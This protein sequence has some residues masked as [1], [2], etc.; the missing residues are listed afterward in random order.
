MGISRKGDYACRI[1]RAC[2]RAEGR[3]ISVAEIAEQEDIPYSFARSIQHNLVRAGFLKT[4]RGARG[5]V[6]L[7]K[8]PAEITLHDVLTAFE[9][10][11]GLSR[12]VT[13]PETCDKSDECRFRH[14]WN[15]ADKLLRD[16]LEG[17]TLADLLAE[18]ETPDHA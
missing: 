14:A 8:S 18:P 11:V 10:P 1:L 7:A 13:E 3:C 17:I 5:G 2:Y 9:G 16:Y 6:C 12:C 4:A 15:G